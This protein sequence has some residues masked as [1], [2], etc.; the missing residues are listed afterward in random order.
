VYGLV[1]RVSYPEIALRLLREFCSLKFLLLVLIFLPVSS[2]FAQETVFEVPSEDILDKGQIYGE[3][4][5]IFLI[6]Q[7]LLLRGL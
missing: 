2:A 3:L 1:F 7:Q 6:R 4:D 5:G